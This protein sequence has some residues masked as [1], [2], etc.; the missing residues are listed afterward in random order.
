[1]AIVEESR[2]VEALIASAEHLSRQPM[3]NE[4]N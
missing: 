2:W 3:K 1:L 4:L